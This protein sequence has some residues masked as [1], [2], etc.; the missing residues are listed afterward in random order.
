MTVVEFLRT[1]IWRVIPIANQ[2]LVAL[3]DGHVSFPWKDL[4]RW[5]C[6]AALALATASSAVAVTC[7]PGYNSQAAT[8]RIARQ[9]SDPKSNANSPTISLVISC[10]TA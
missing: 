7:F 4:P 10:L 8:A 2:R 3:Q 5:I 6:L 1:T 9:F